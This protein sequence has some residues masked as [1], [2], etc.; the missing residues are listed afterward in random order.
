[1]PE[2]PPD[3][4]SEPM[5]AALVAATQRAGRA[6]LEIYESEFEVRRKSDTSPVTEADLA[7]HDLIVAVLGELTP[8][9]PLLSEE[10]APP[11]YSERRAGGAI[12]WLTPSM[13]R[14]NSSIATG[15]SPSILP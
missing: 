7:A 6:I 14:G 15:S 9:I 10:S 1:M 4:Y 8:D 5:I 13:E 3:P 2:T 12:G 11:P